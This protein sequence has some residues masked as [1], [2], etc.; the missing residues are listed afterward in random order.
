MNSKI[1]LE[2]FKQGKAS[3]EE[4]KMLYQMLK[5]EHNT[6]IM[7]LIEDEWAGLKEDGKSP[8]SEQLLN[9][10]YKKAG[11]IQDQKKQQ[12]RSLL[13]RRMLQYAAVFLAAFLMSWFLKPSSP[14]Q[15]ADTT[16]EKVNYFRIKVPYG[17][18]STIEL[19]DSTKVILNSGSTLEYP[20]HFG[21]SDRTVFL[22]GE[23]YFDVKRNKQ[24]PFFV[25]TSEASIKVLGTQ[26]NVKS[27]SGEDHMETTLVSGSIEILPNETAYN[28]KR[29]AYRRILL[30]PNE[31]AV[32]MHND[33]SIVKQGIDKVPERILTA[34]VLFQDTEI[35]QTDIAWKNDILILNNEP[36]GEIV[37]KLERWYNVQITLND[38][39]LSKI[40]FSARFKGESI[41]DV[42]HALSLTQ[43]F[44]YEV[45]K[46]LITINNNKR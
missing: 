44:E 19:P 32:F 39:A 23:A 30:K 27:Y 42:L 21:A 6:E 10:I 37:S 16:I 46:N 11:I 29:Q 41:V 7:A 18:K 40:R 20:D 5:E 38:A 15:M 14:R 28:S 26:F 13:I 31:K 35:T 36:F 22:N 33:I 25:K 4:L 24:K 8:A 45:N 17:S 34:S 1:L 43:P 12:G 3:S 2:K 9:R